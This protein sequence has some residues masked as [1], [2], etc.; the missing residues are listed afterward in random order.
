MWLPTPVYERVP[1]FWI[2]MGLLFFSLGLYIGFDF[3][4]IFVYLAVGLACLVRGIWCFV[5]RWSFRSKTEE[6][7]GGK[8]A[9]SHSDIK[10]DQTGATHV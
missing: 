10:L 1:D 3:E 7:P 6:M 4:L 2:L 8:D 9:A 5:V